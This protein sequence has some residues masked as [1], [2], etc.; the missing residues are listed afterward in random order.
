MMK[1]V[2]LGLQV[3]DKHGYE[4]IM[5]HVHWKADFTIR[6]CFFQPDENARRGFEN[7]E[8]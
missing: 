8:A 7:C 4:S 2:H 1:C 6:L 3:Y 5:F